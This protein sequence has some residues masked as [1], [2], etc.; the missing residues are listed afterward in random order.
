[1]K[2][3][4]INIKN[5]RRLENVQIDFESSE[6]IFVGPNNSGKT[7]T[8]AILRCFL[9][10]KEFKIHDFSVAQIAVIDAFGMGDDLT[11]LPTI[12]LDLWFSIDAE[13]ISFGQAFTLLPEMSENLDKVGIRLKYQPRNPDKTLS[14]YRAV[15]EKTPQKS[16]SKFLTLEG[17]LKQNYEI[18]Y[19]SIASDKAKQSEN[20][21]D[22]TDGKTLLNNL[23]RVDFL[24]AQR[25]VNDEEATRSSRLSTAFSAFY[26]KNLEQAEARQN[27][28]QVI[29]EN[30]EKLTIHYA[31][32][33]ERL[34]G[35]IKDLGVPSGNDRSIKIISALSPEV[36]LQGNTELIYIDGE[37]QHELPESYNGLG[38]K[39][40]IYMTIQIVHFHLQWIKTEKNRPLCQLI[41]IEEPE[42]HLHAQ[43]QQ[44]FISNIWKTITK[45]AEELSLKHLVPQFVISTHSSHILDAVDF[46]KVRYFERC[47]L[48]GENPLGV[49]TFNASK[50]HSLR[51][52]HPDPV[53][54]DESTVIS[55]EE[56]KK[57]L[58]KYLKLTHCDLFFADAAILVEG[59]VEKLLISKMISQSAPLLQ[60]KYIS[61]L[62]IGGAYAHRFDGL[63]KFINIPYLIITDL[64]SVS[65]TGKHPACRGDIP[66]ALTSNASLKYFF[67]ETKVD[68]LLQISDKGKISENNNRCVVFQTGVDVSQGKNKLQ[69]I[70]RTIEESFI[71]ENF[72]IFL[73]GKIFKLTDI[74]SN[75]SSAYETIYKCVGSSNFKKTEFALNVLSSDEEWKTPGYIA[76]GLK[77]L[78]NRLN[79]IATTQLNKEA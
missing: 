11:F 39:N 27:A 60:S 40:L 19:Y 74:S 25:S 63:L 66:D 9:D 42:V 22:S 10:G 51:N 75:L 21:I 41:F 15:C 57:F 49:K 34:M 68:K 52:F 8:A 26:K 33:F 73:A 32:H 64:D 50:V 24:D 13:K 18:A 44:A 67:K 6:T 12:E 46:S 5:F 38:F 14:E 59:T 1:M 71:Y 48:A 4:H 43:V 55:P 37:Y 31:Q 61:I 29:N 2:L 78:E 69:M 70:P 20:R 7:S 17:S 36:A 77:W 54:I 53:N 35:I 45:S 58:L 65:A 3:S 62:E 47:A 16:L 30:N 72:S 79:K 76:I 56:A 23:L 28:Y